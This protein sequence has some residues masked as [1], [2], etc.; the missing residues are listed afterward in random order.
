MKAFDCIPKSVTTLQDI[1]NT[2]KIVE[3]VSMLHGFRHIVVADDVVSRASFRSP[4]SR[5]YL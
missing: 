4:F 2:L 5:G 3:L 1:V